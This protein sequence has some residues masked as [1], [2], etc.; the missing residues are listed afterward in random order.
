[1][2]VN[3]LH[4]GMES[5]VELYTKMSYIPSK[6]E[7]RFASTS[8]EESSFRE[9]QWEQPTFAQTSDINT[10]PQIMPSTLNCSEQI[11]IEDHVNNLC[12]CSPL[13]D[14]PQVTTQK[15]ISKWA[16]LKLHQRQGGKETPKT[17]TNRNI[18]SNESS[19]LE[20]LLPHQ[21]PVYVCQC[22]NTAR[23]AYYSS[24]S[25]P[26]QKWFSPKTVFRKTLS[27]FSENQCLSCYQYETLKASNK[28]E[29]N[30]NT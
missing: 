22:S 17:L 16:C 4:T 25:L 19:R 7:N 27:N 28:F 5:S 14:I 6:N 9:L 13:V 8:K 18:P 30:S 26:L 21:L 20:R 11:I 12:T 3:I 1:M 2:K 15:H 24:P 29:S 10:C 23:K